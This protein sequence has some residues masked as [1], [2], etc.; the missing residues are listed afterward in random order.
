[1]DEV[2]ETL[3]SVVESEDQQAAHHRLQAEFLLL[4]LTRK[5][6]L[7]WPGRVLKYLQVS[8]IYFSPR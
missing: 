3:L 4:R 6:E 5:M 2:S 8:A 7:L 1:M